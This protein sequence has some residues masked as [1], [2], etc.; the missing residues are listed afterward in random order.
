MCMRSSALETGRDVSILTRKGHIGVG[1]EEGVCWVRGEK[2]KDRRWKFR[3]MAKRKKHI[4]EVFHD[5]NSDAVLGVLRTLLPL[6]VRLA[7]I[8]P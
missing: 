5:I 8:C 1:C 7:G 4:E 3:Y 6:Q 2:S